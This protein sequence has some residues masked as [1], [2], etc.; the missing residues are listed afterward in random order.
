MKKSLLKEFETKVNSVMVHLQL[1]KR[2][3]QANETLRQYVYAMSTIASQGNVE[4]EAVMQYIIDG[5]QDDEAAKS[6]LYSACTIG[7]LR[8]NLE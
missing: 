8:K 4:E 7:E 5:I 6:I 3:R 2:K 1:S